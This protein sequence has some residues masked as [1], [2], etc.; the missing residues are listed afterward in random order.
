MLN[1]WVA[2]GAVSGP[3]RKCLQ[4]S[5]FPVQVHAREAFVRYPKQDQGRFCFDWLRLVLYLILVSRDPFP[6]NIFSSL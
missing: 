4:L 1:V 5:V 6:L 2:H 3:E